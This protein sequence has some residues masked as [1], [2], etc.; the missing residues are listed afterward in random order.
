MIMM[1][2]RLITI[3]LSTAPTIMVVAAVE[4]AAVVMTCLEI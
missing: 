2:L 4:A 3:M 1:K